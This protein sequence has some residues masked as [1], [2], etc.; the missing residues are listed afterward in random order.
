MYVFAIKNYSGIDV[1]E[2]IKKI[3][4]NALKM[5]SGKNSIVFT[6]TKNKKLSN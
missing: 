2:K 5:D 6:G 4:K 3:A 1:P